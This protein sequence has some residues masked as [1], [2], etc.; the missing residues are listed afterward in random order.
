LAWDAIFSVSREDA[1][2]IFS[3]QSIGKSAGFWLVSKVGILANSLSQLGG[4][5]AGFSSCLVC[6]S[7]LDRAKSRSLLTSEAV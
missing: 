1:L 6:F 5:L 3:C 7:W 4:K 2:F